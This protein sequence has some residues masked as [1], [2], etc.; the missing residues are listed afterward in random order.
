MAV[1]CESTKTTP[2]ELTFWDELIRI[3]LSYR[4]NYND[5]KQEL[6]MQSKEIEWDD[7]LIIEEGIGCIHEDILDQFGEK[8]QNY[9][10]LARH[11]SSRK[12]LQDKLIHLLNS[13][14]SI[15]NKF[16]LYPRDFIFLM[17][18]LHSEIRMKLPF[19]KRK[20]LKNWASPI[21]NDD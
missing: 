19:P 4:M 12:E 15:L 8:L 7:H 1:E 2:P 9:S 10:F 5:E 6:I 13:N 11:Y 18:Q 16:G 17:R 20:K 3:I 14:Q 21:S